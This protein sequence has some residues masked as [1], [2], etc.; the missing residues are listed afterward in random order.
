MPTIR[1]ALALVTLSLFVGTAVDAENY[2][3]TPGDELMMSLSASDEPRLARIGPDGT[4]RVRSA[5]GVPVAGMTLDAAE[6]RSKRRSRLPG[7]SSRP[8]W[9][10]RSAAM[11]PSSSRATWRHRGATIICRS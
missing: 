6:A 3:L 11:P 7:S 5:G 1:D 4:V 8:M 9:T 2:L 10:S